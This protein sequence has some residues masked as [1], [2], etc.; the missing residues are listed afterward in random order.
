MHRCGN[1]NAA[2][3]SFNH[4]PGSESAVVQ[5]HGKGGSACGRC[6]SNMLD[7]LQIPEDYLVVAWL[8][9]SKFS[10]IK[11]D[12]TRR[13]A[14]LDCGSHVMLAS[15]DRNPDANSNIPYAWRSVS[16]IAPQGNACGK[17]MPN[18]SLDPT[19]PEQVEDD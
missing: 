16:P 9:L 14:L 11:R 18:D 15:E 4:I 13:D 3:F 12:C 8:T 17:S 19:M 2:K 1:P 10:R 5:N 6:S 7:S